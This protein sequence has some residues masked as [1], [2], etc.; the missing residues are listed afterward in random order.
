MRTATISEL[1]ENLSDFLQDC[2]REA[3]VVTRDGKPVAVL[4]APADKEELERLVLAHSSKFRA[5]L[6]K[7]RRQIRATG[8]IPHEEFWR[9]VDADHVARRKGKRKRQPI[10]KA[11]K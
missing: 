3:V 8:G 11:T 10:S 4:V 9:Q 2:E 7:S 6:E 5:I 1:R